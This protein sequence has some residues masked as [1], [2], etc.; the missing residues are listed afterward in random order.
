M[1]KGVNEHDRTLLICSRSSLGRPGLLNEI[2]EVM[3]RESRDGGKT[4][5]IPIRLDDYVFSG[6][7]PE[8]PDL[9]QAV[10]DRVVADFRQHDD[11]PQ[12]ASELAKLI[13]VLKKA[14]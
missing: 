3:A 14:V 11:V 5:L 6:W 10:R 7:V 2:E 9:A 8:N 13:A 12:F 1:R 4:Y